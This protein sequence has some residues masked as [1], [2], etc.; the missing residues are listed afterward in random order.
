MVEE[1]AIQRQDLVWVLEVEQGQ[2]GRVKQAILKYEY[3]QQFQ[4]DHHVPS[5]R[6][7]A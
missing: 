4:D 6:G 5:P 7:Q 3:L 1:Q 2:V